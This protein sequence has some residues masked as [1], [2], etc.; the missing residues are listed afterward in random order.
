MEFTKGKIAGARE[1]EVERVVKRGIRDARCRSEAYQ[2]EV[3]RSGLA[4]LCREGSWKIERG[5]TLGIMKGGRWE[6]HGREC[7]RICWRRHV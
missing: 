3:G 4:W 7:M 5:W 1:R 2:M 6:N